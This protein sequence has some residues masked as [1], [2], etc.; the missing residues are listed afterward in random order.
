ML[1][2]E[3]ANPKRKIIK[4][5][6]EY[7]NFIKENNGITNLYKT[8]YKF[9][10]LKNNYQVDYESAIIDKMFFDCDSENSLEVVKKFHNYLI[11]KDIKHYLVQSSYLKFHIY[12]ICKVTNLQ[13]KK[14]ALYNGMVYLAKG[15]GLSYGE[16][17]TSDLD[18]ATFG[19]LARIHPIP[20][21]YKPKRK[22]FT[23]Y[24]SRDY[25][26][27]D[28]MLKEASKKG[29]GA[30]IIYGTKEFDLTPFDNF[31]IYESNTLSMVIDND[32]F[33]FE[34]DDKVVSK[35]PPFIQ[36]I[37]TNYK[38]YCNDYKNRWRVG[39]Y[40][41]DMGFS[42]S[43][44][45]EILKKYYSKVINYSSCN[46]NCSQWDRFVKCKALYYIFHGEFREFPTIQTLLEEGWEITKKDEEMFERLYGK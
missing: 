24:I 8:L 32:D 27:N 12:V 38:E 23:S 33:K 31:E 1:Y 41:R 25:L 45:K 35:L 20:R 44:T 37:L 19:D 22:A 28:K 13:N 5:K 9:K 2:L 10:Y 14:N 4:S 6:E 42:E 30:K 34:L 36:K 3:V 18:K 29:N 26:F 11:K 46:G 39:L 16:S 7:I 21:T 40:L 15:V 43:M 17:K